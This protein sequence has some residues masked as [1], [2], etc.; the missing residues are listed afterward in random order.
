MRLTAE[1]RSTLEGTASSMVSS[2][3]VAGLAAYGSKVAG[4]ARPDSDYDLIIVSKRFREGIRYKYVEKPVAASALIVDEH[5]LS[6]DAQSSYL[7]EFVVGRFLNVYEPITNPE[8]FKGLELEY[9]RRVMVE[10]LLELS[11]DYGDFCRHLVV[12]YDYFLFEKLSKR[13]SMYPP[14]LYSYVQ[15]YT[16]PLG[17]ENRR[18]STD[19]F[20]SA[21]EALA[22][23]GFLSLAPAGVVIAPEK[24]K[25]D[26]FTKVQSI[27]SLTTRGLTQYAVHGYAGRVGLSVYRREA[28]SKLKRMREAPRPLAELEKPRSL[29]RLEEGVMIPD[30]SLLERELAG[31]LGFSNYSTRERDIG[32]PSSVTRVLTFADG[33]R[34]SPVVI[35]SYSDVRSLKWALLGIWAAAANKFSMTPMARLDR[36][37]AMTRNLRRNGVLVPAILAVAPGERIM[38]K[39]FISGPTLSS[40][41]DGL[42]KGNPEG[43]GHVSAYAELMAKVHGAGLA[44]GDAKASNV[45]VSPHG[46]YLTDLEQ[47]APGGDTAWDIAE[48]LYYTAKFSTREEAMSRVARSFLGSYVSS[49][50]RE[51]LA[52]ARSP[53]Y[54]RPFQ[55]FV[56]P[57]MAHMLQELMMELC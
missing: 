14:A 56:T 12:P 50:S 41:I 10:A 20:A 13:A 34:E 57:G 8:L 49:G 30:A 21:A 43:M 36:E 17:A 52:K 44:L 23:R 4:Y 6:Q 2:S 35:K 24:M 25:G 46:L 11:E 31:L 47:S 39:E 32:D 19:G 16:C 27:F 45:V 29:L 40:V 3:S 48:F 51:A 37:Y 15:T 7:G 33:T 18:V 26:A 54:Y 22:Y 42:L 53:K 5:L 1:E 55:P 28:Q 38:V 9:K